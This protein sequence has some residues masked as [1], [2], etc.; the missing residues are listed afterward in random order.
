MSVNYIREINAFY[1]GLE[2]NPLSSS[3]IAL[4]YALMHINNKSG[5]KDKFSV[6]VGTLS[7]K[8]GLSERSISNARNELKTKGY[9][10]FQSRGGNKAAM[11]QIKCLSAYIAD[12]LSGN[13]SYNLSDSP[14]DYPSGNASALFKHKLN[15]T[16]K[17]INNN[18]T[19]GP[20]PFRIFESEGFGTLSQMIAEKLGDLIDDFSERWVCEAMRAAVHQGKRNLPYVKAILDRYKSSGVDEPW[21]VERKSDAPT[22]VNRPTQQ[23]KTNY[24][25]KPKLAVVDDSKHSSNDLSDDRLREMCRTSRKIDGKSEPTEGD[26]AEFIKKMR[27]SF[28]QPAI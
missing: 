18:P 12:N 20:N 9:L 3:A 22:H 24:S 4:W 5:W 2:I 14:S 23:R 16:K 21:T 19:T 6:P 11:Y 1:N 7:L 17:E 28:P 26:Y 13:T 8:S 27:R 10:D 25:G 15:E